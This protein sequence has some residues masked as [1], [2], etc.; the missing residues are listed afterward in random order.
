ME[1]IN[2]LKDHVNGL[3]EDGIT[4]VDKIMKYSLRVSPTIPEELKKYIIVNPLIIDQ[5]IILINNKLEKWVNRYEY[6]KIIE[7]LSNYDFSKRENADKVFKCLLDFMIK[8]DYIKNIYDELYTPIEII[9]PDPLPDPNIVIEKLQ[10]R[11]N[12]EDAINRILKY[13][14]ETGIH[15]QATGCGKTNIILYYLDYTIKKFKEKAKIILFT[16]RVN[17]LK[18]LFD[19]SKDGNEPNKFN[20]N[21]WKKQGI[22]DL[23]LENVDFI[24]R[25]TIKKTDWMDKLINNKKATILVINRAYLTSDVSKYSMMKD[26]VSLI[27]HDEC[28]NTSSVRCNNFLIKCKEYNI[29]IVGF[30]ATPLRTGKDDKSKLLD[31]Y[32]DPDNNNLLKLLT[33]YNM[34]YAISK[35]LILPPEFYWYHIDYNAYNNLEPDDDKLQYE[36]GTVLEILNNVV[37]KLPNKKIV[38]WCGRIDL[39]KKWKKLFE[40]NHKQKAPLHGFKFYLDTSQTK[41]DDYKEFRNSDGKCIMFCANK[42]REGSDIM[43]LDCCIFLDG[44]KNR[45]CIPFIQSI[46]R[47][48]RHDINFN[49]KNGVVIDGIYRYKDYER[50]FIDKIIGYYVS[51][52]NI[53]EDID[54]SEKT[55]YD[56]YIELKNIINFD[57]DNE[58]IYLNFN[59]NKISI[60]VNKLHWDDIISKF[61]DILQKKIKLSTQDN[62]KHKGYIL[63]SNFGFHQNTDFYNEYLKISSEDKN[64]YNLPDI[65]SDEYNQLFNTKTWFDFLGITHTFYKTPDDA[66]KGLIKNN[67][68]LENPEKNWLEWCKKDN[69][70]PMYPKYIWNKDYL[71]VFIEKKGVLFL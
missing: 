30:S 40:D 20:I 53:S 45:G 8:N 23:D 60:N 70:L 36:L 10:L 56:K 71:K 35:E 47:V 29:P 44:V 21:K 69:M 33:N 19:F 12:Q 22:A 64:K 32:G 43:K 67:I 62:M 55:N 49:K 58:K 1:Q 37:P 59:S 48:L 14:L 46:G 41:D 11:C 3:K 39:S 26:V 65:D 25:V 66:R 24:N 9:E 27:L 5:S 13:G 63:V 50:D 17:I 57:P 38:A 16:E 52:Q 34:I 51:L 4:D 54:N 7:K 15:C 18:D 68:K 28:H 31:I 6:E 61:D 2:D 42:H